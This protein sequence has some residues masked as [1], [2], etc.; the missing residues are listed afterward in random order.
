MRIPSLSVRTSTSVGSAHYTLLV[1]QQQADVRAAQRLRYQVFA[2]EMGAVLRTAE[3]G[4]DIDDFD[5]Y[6]DH[7]VVRDDC[8]GQIVGTYRM[9]SPEGARRAGELYCE[10]EF[11]IPSLRSLRGSLVET[12]RSCVHPDHRTGAV[13]NLIWAGIARYLLL[14]G[15][16][17]LVGCASVPLRS[18]GFADGALASGVWDTVRTRHLAP[19]QYRV[20]PRLPWRA[21]L[22]PRPASA[23]MPPLLR[24]YLRLGAWVCGPPA[25]DRDFGV[26]DFL[27][28]L[29][30]DQVDPRYL[31]HFLGDSTSPAAATRP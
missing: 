21:D 17:W 24:G 14:S 19:E 29:S 31:R 10:T 7:L 20:L 22:A 27:V 12:G 11:Q 26:A 2:G 30:L 15:Y 16:R 13:V 9:L 6:C 3:A 18:P 23:S 28:L 4:L 5:A 1:A 25:H 8:T